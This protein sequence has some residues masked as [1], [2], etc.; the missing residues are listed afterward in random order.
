MNIIEDI[1]NVGEKLKHWITTTEQEL[2]S[3]PS[4]ESRNSEDHT[5]SEDEMIDEA[6]IESFPASD[7]PGHRSKS[8]RDRK[9]HRC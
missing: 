3:R 1:K 7:P 5:L 9:D 6:G 2:K 4:K 8:K